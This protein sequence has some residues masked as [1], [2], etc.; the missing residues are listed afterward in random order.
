M[1]GPPG[2]VTLTT[3]P[4]EVDGRARCVP[5]EIVCEDRVVECVGDVGRVCVDGAFIEYDCAA[6]GATCV[7][8]PE[9]GF[10]CEL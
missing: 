8:E 9:D 6:F 10:R 4:R 3:M 7:E 1:T 2:Q 5:S